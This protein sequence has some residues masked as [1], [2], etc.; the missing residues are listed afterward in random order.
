MLAG[1][2][3]M[4]ASQAVAAVPTTVYT[5]AT[6]LTLTYSGEPVLGKTVKFV[7]NEKNENLGLLVMSSIFDLSAIPGIPESMAKQI[8]GPGVVPGSPELSVPVTLKDAGNGTYTFSGSE[9]T[10]HLTFNYSGTISTD[11]LD[12]AITDAR[13][14]DQTL[15]G[16]WDLAPMLMDEEGYEVI[17]RPFEI[18]WES[19]ELLKLSEGFEMPM[20]DILALAL[21][22][23]ILEEGT[24]SV[25]DML[26]QVL[27]QIQ[28]EADGNVRARVVADGREV[29][30]PANMVQ[31][32]VRG[33]NDFGLYLDPAAIAAYD[34]ELE[35]GTRAAGNP[36][37]GI[38][39]DLENI[40]A[41]LF[42]YNHMLCEGVPMHYRLADGKLCVYIGDDL[43]LPMLKE[44]VLPLIND[45]ALVQQ[46]VE[47]IKAGG[48]ETMLAMADMIPGLMESLA[49]VINTT[50]KIEI[51][52]NF[53]ANTAAVE[54]IDA[55]AS[56]GV[57]MARYDLNGMPVS[58]D[59]KGLVIV[60]YADGSARKLIVR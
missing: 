22:M 58:T 17:S 27:K 38:T 31:Y 10:S 7:A 59:Y 6:G 15:V 11:K 43:L 54:R 39:I 50:T 52:L 9:K 12:I 60:C 5:Q 23:P 28:F 48:D 32:V 2:A 4:F 1:A 16:L 3:M 25:S 53:T 36:G 29:F 45:K 47:M 19:E 20:A 24:V 18:V 56:A 37:E 41:N 35:N 13:L 46:L 55:S 40:L 8:P 26:P 49:G 14:L 42:R 21:V 30:A 33:N 51:G 57:E 34:R 44:V